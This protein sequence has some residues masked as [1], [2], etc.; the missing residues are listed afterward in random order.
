MGIQERVISWTVMETCSL[1]AILLVCGAGKKEVKTETLGMRE[2]MMR[3]ERNADDKRSVTFV[4]LSQIDKLSYEE[5]ELSFL[6]QTFYLF[7]LL[8]P[9]PDYHANDFSCILLLQILSYLC[10]EVSLPVMCLRYFSAPTP[11]SFLKRLDLFIF[12]SFTNSVL[13]SIRSFLAFC[14]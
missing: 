2:E 7:I 11:I 8:F 5:K 13:V 10:L 1:C 12:N 3:I 9:T 6:P 14:K 4:N